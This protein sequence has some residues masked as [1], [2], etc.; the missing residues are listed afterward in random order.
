MCRVFS[1]KREGDVFACGPSVH[2]A[3]GG[4]NAQRAP[5]TVG[6][7][8][9]TMAAMKA[10]MVGVA[11]AITMGACGDD[12]DPDSGGRDAGSLP[13]AGPGFDAGFD[14][15][16]PDAGRGDAGRDCNRAHLR[17]VTMA[18]TCGP[19]MVPEV[20]EECWLPCVDQTQCAPIECIVGLFPLECPND[21]TCEEPGV[22]TP[23]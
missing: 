11:C 15:G 7:L 23:P 6:A 19:G 9:G 3:A 20:G 8:I 21:W 13:D 12:S 5:F 22:C 4:A 18:P 14:G 1:A 17:C 10:L 16:I 2:R